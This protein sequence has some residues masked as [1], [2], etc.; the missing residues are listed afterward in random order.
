MPPIL[1]IQGISKHFPGVQALQDVSF[2]VEEGAIHAVMGENGAG[3]STLMQVIAG[4]H[5]PDSG[6]LELAVLNL[7]LNARDAMPS[8]GVIVIDARNRTEDQGEA[9][10]EMVEFSVADPGVGM[11]EEVLARACEPFFTTKDVGKGSGLGL[12][13]V[14]AFITSSGGAL[15][16]D[17]K[18]GTGTTVRLRFPR[19]AK[20]SAAVVEDEAPSAAAD[21]QGKKGHVLLVEDDREVAVLSQEML[22]SIGFDVTHAA[23]AEAALGALALR[24]KARGRARADAVFRFSARYGRAP[25]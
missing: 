19:S 15:S 21:G 24:S 2:D 3:K 1:K 17:S 12:S 22:A 6:E 7:C 4:V 5:Q 16:I 20:V 25:P 11:P 10:R 18:P 23:S 13:Q 9:P 8:G 14:Y